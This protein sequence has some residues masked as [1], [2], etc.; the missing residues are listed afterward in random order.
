MTTTTKLSLDEEVPETQL[1]SWQKLIALMAQLFDVPSGLIMRKHPQQNEIEVLVTNEHPSNPYKVNEHTSLAANL[2]CK[3]AMNNDEILQVP[4]ALEDENWRNNNPD[5]PLGM[6]SYLGLPLKRNDGSTFGTI[7]V[8]DKQT[9]H[10]NK[11][12]QN[13]LRQ[14]KNTI[15][16]DLKL[17]EKNKEIEQQNQRIIKSIS[18]AS[19]MQQIIL[20]KNDFLADTFQEHFIIYLPKD[21]VSGD[22]YWS[23]RVHNK[24]FLAVIDC[25]GHGVPGAFMSMI[26]HTLL[27]NIINEQSIHN[28]ANILNHLH[29]KIQATLKQKESKNTDG[30]DICLC[31]F[32]LKND[33]ITEL[34]YAGA[35][36]SLFI[37][38][39]NTL[40]EWKGDRKNI[41]GVERY[42]QNIPFNNQSVP[43]QKGDV[44]YL[45]SDGL[46]D[47]PNPARKSFGTKKLKEAL[48]KV[49]SL[50]LNKQRQLLLQELQ[51]HQKNT[52]QRDDIT[53][54]GVKI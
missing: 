16:N 17:I 2:Y 29:S 21:E 28:P 37:A 40:Q 34:I 15:E 45:M 41:G 52:P 39:N 38:H 6:I 47:A 11:D 13:L 3:V 26:A 30:L 42:Q 53:L 14:F 48:L 24:V 44:I 9:R 27:H 54:L 1:A 12:Y 46:V 7:C 35:K 31:R 19:R 8:L 23:T 32:Q 25:T 50:P 43:F 49:S 36:R 10:Y 33:T 22:F 20:A 18:Y 51:Q 4:N 5:V